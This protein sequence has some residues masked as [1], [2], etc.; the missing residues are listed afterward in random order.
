MIIGSSCDGFYGI[1]FHFY[2]LMLRPT[3]EPELLNKTVWFTQAP[4]GTI[5]TIVHYSP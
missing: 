5:I 4:K 3:R 1:R 2:S